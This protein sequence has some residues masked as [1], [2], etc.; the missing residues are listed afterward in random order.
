MG[1]KK[2]YYKVFLMVHLWV[3]WFF[4][5]L[6]NSY[7]LIDLIEL[8]GFEKRNFHFKIVAFILAGGG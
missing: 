1:H 7:N 3:D 5:N 2:T 6:F 4:F 8:I